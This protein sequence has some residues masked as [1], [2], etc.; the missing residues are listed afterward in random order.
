MN[1]ESQGYRLLTV[2]CISLYIRNRLNNIKTILC[3]AILFRKEI[4][5][6][7]LLTY[8]SG[9]VVGILHMY[10]RTLNNL[11]SSYR[12]SCHRSCMK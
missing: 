2:F 10:L 9:I 6:E 5:Y 1:R 8:A 12:T 3:L 7:F 4:H 11:F